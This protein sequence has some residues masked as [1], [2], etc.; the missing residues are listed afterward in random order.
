MCTV[1]FIVLWETW[2]TLNFTKN[3]MAAK[4]IPSQSQRASKQNKYFK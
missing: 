4:K 3:K 2:L 1:N